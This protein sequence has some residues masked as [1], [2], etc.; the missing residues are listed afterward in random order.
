MGCCSA[1]QSFSPSTY[2][3]STLTLVI[4]LLETHRFTVLTVLEVLVQDFRVH[5]TV[6]PS[7]PLSRKTAPNMFPPPCLMEGCCSLGHT[8]YFFA[9]KHSWCQSARFHLTTALCPK[10]SL[11][12]LKVNWQTLNG[13]VLVPSWAEASQVLQ[14]FNPLQQSVL[15]VVFLTGDPTS[16]RSSTGS[17]SVVLR[18]SG[19]FLMIIPND[20]LEIDGHFIFLTFSK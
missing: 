7:C 4:V 10:P 18:W 5:G 12:R 15:P 14:D 11:S 20:G 3:L 6:K 2:Y 17:F 8:Q 19:T 13:S 1:P 16:V 9:S